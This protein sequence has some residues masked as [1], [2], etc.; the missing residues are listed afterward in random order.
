MADGNQTTLPGMGHNAPP[1]FRQEV[2]DAHAAKASEFLDAAG[3]WLEAG[4]I[5][6]EERA[7]QLTDFITGL[8]A[9]KS[10]IEEDRKT[11]KKPHDDAGKAVQAAY[12]PLADKIDK[13]LGKVNPLMGA[14]LSKVEAEQRAEAERKRKEAEEAQ[15]AAEEKARQAQARHDVSGEYDAE[16]AQKAAEKAHKDA[17]RAAKAR[18]KASSATGGGR[19]ISMRTVWT[20]ELADMKAAFM[21]FADHPEVEAVLVR[22]AEAKARSRDFD[23]TKQTIPGFTLTAK[24]VPA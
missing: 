5:E 17:D 20:A 6:T 21:Q 15:R 3:E 8:K 18:P 19:A 10:K 4:A 14:Y 12:K 23:P 11:D 16:E 9:V 7:A 24:K 2:V 22:L 1:V 13:A